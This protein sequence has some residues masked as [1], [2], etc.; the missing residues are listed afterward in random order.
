MRR[1]SPKWGG[2]KPYYSDDAVTIYHGD[3]REILPA[4]PHGSLVLT[5]PPYGIGKRW[6]TR[7]PKIA[8]RGSSRLWGHAET[9]D[10][11]TPAPAT[12]ALAIAAGDHAI[13][14][15]GNYF[16]LAPG[17]CW[18]VW[19]KMQKFNGAEAELAWTNIDLPV[20]VFR[21][22]RIDAFVNQADSLKTHPTEKPLPLMR[23]CLNVAPDAS[24][25]IDPF[26]GSGTTLRAAKDRGV[27]AIGI[28]RDE[29]YCEIAATRMGQ[30][31]MDFGAAA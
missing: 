20:R 4:I 11:D 28:E 2:V 23:W 31:V 16:G 19:D 7:G 17:R 14:W 18:L 6:A 13:I 30:E 9:W 1:P 12:L 29:A 15:G 22:S 25:V 3:C 5:D 21:L 8:K 27:R 10:D 24:S 26:M